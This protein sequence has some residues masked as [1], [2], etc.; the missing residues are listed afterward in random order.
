MRTVGASTSPLI[1]LERVSSDLQHIPSLWQPYIMPPQ[2]PYDVVVLGIG[3]FGQRIAAELL[4]LLPDARVAIAGRSQAKLQA[5]RQAILVRAAAQQAAQLARAAAAARPPDS[6]GASGSGT[7]K[8]PAAS[9]LDEDCLG[10]V[11][12]CEACDA[13]AMEGLASSTRVLVAALSNY[14]AVGDTVARACSVKGTAYFDLCT[15]TDMHRQWAEEFGA[16][17]R[18]TGSLIVPCCG[19]DY[20]LTDFGALLTAR[21]FEPPATLQSIESV[22]SM[23]PG[24]TGVVL[25]ES[26][27]HNLMQRMGAS[28]PAAP[29]AQR[30]APRRPWGP[31]IKW[32]EAAQCWT[33]PN[34]PKE[35]EVVAASQEAL[36]RALPWI[37]PVPYASRVAMPSLLKSAGMAASLVLLLLAKIDPIRRLIQLMVPPVLVWAGLLTRDIA[38]YAR[39][40][41]ELQVH[42]VFVATGSAGGGEG[43]PAE[44]VERVLEITA[45]SI[46]PSCLALAAATVLQEPGKI[47]ASGIA[48]PVAAFHATSY[49]QRLVERCGIEVCERSAGSRHVKAA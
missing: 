18:A 1:R 21:L 4:Q 23:R 41:D 34:V 17:A 12:H 40:I 39:A 11:G 42:K 26:S 27:F 45:G 30:P 6:P 47:Q 36:S 9:Q 19:I 33:V 31:P 43:A 32:S 10:L 14:K 29:A 25:R 48:T 20:V 24:P 7:P 5:A 49:W 44:A 13:V 2:R 35:A 15:E 16:E 8:R 3:F 38:V 28:K 46:T 37:R 22:L